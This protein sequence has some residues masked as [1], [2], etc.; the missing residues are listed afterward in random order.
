MLTKTSNGQSNEEAIWKL[1]S[2]DVKVE[3]TKRK[4]V[5]HVR[6]NLMFVVTL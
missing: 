2:T 6:T 5:D 1:M 3:K 4:P